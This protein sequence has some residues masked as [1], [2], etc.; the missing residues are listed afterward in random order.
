M[1]SADMGRYVGRP[2]PRL[3]DERLVT[4][5]GRFTDDNAIA[6]VAAMLVR[7]PHAHGLIRSIRIDRALASPGVLAVLTDADY[8]ADGNNDIRHGPTPLDTMDINKPAFG[9]RGSTV[10][11][12]AMPPLATD[13][14]R[15]LGQPVAIV[16]AETE[17]QA[18]Y[19]TE[20]V[21]VRYELHPASVTPEMAIAAEAPEIWPELPGNIALDEHF[22]DVAGTEEA[23]RNADV[24]IE[25]EF[26][27]QRLVVMQMEPRVVIGTYSAA[28]HR[29][30]LFAATQGVHRQR[31]ALAKALNVPVSR[32]RVVTG[33]VGGGFGPRTFLEPESV[34][35]CWAAR[36][37][38]RAVRWR[39][40]RSESFLTDLQGRDTV[41]NARL[42]FDNAGRAKAIKLDLLGN[43][44]AHSVSYVP[45]ANAYRHATTVYDI[46]LAAVHVRG[47][48]TNTVS[49]APFRGAGRPDMTYMMERLM[50]LSAHRLCID[51][52]ELRRRN[53]I[54][55]SALPYRTAMGVSYDAGD[56]VASI[57]G[58]QALADWS[59]FATRRAQSLAR[60]MRR[61]I[62]LS[63]YVQ[64]PAGA[65][66][67]RVCLTA[68][69]AGI[70][71]VIIGTQSTGQGH[72]TS[73]AQVVADQLG[74]APEQVRLVTGDTDRVEVGGGTHS[75]RSMKLA[76]TLIFEASTQLLAQAAEIAAELYGVHR[77]EVSLSGGE[78]STSG[79]NHKL[80]VLDIARE[81]PDIALTA[82]VDFVGRILAFPCG[83]A[84]CEL[85]VDPETGEVHI[86]NYSSVDDVGQPINPMI[87]EG[88]TK[89]GIT[90][91]IGQALCEQVVWEPHTGQMLT[92][93]LMDY[94]V[95][96]ADML[97]SF[98]LATLEDAT[99]CNPL[100]VKGG[101]EGG[102]VAA[103][104]AVINA[105]CDALAAD[106]VLDVPSP[107]TPER[108]WRALIDARKTSH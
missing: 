18:R 102:V 26:S 23:L 25:W 22:G 105:I 28:D 67:E 40:D 88:Q 12:T 29:Y 30:T 97:P 41:I 71:E 94:A 83:C 16:I 78:C 8:R 89:G 99:E 20:Q 51:R 11:D 108:I 56:F 57:D 38:G 58:A 43:V 81:R 106:G 1:G 62:G 35:V 76:G 60:G 5:K 73:F 15:F 101:G 64:I 85:E 2:L 49:T 69:P 10:H 54:P 59:G 53:L 45:L 84:V 74:I 4:G 47:V 37:L 50:D 63:A 13:R 21:A 75:D 65:P 93:S 27:S 34:L 9:E 52:I 91:G 3:E 95:P 96:R 24:V 19:A 72:E 100:H 68:T 79:S 80:N 61:G 7:S 87:V 36:R 82:T 104:A 92:A 98:N 70:V 44:G 90:Q 42:G 31:V 33:D 46:P 6:T 66:R 48:I 77:R 86:L 32:V 103:P 14:V 107:A 55:R 17:A 39:G